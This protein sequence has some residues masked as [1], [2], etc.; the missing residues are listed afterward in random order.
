MILS[1][2][3]NST[4]QT[5]NSTE[6]YIHYAFIFLISCILLSILLY[7]FVICIKRHRKRK[8]NVIRSPSITDIISENSTSE[9]N[10]R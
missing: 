1:T 5:V 8:S 9:T 10:I 2:T 3:I 7:I 4:I 6:K